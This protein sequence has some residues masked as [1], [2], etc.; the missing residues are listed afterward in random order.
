[1][2]KIKLNMKRYLFSVSVAIVLASMSCLTSCNNSSSTTLPGS[3]D[4]LGDFAGIPRDGAV[5]FIINNNAFVGTGYNYFSNTF[6][7]DFWRYEPNSDSWYPAATFPGI[8]RSGAVAFT[9]NG[10]GYI[11]G[12]Y[13]ILNGSTNP[14]SDF[15]VFDPTAGKI[16]AWSQ[17]ASF[18]FPSLPVDSTVAQRYGCGAFHCY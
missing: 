9:M 15:W 2:H 7:T 18:G 13:N 3:W 11:G 10:K 8:A 4:K 1:M 6:L 14:L 17:I 5:S 12:G 16:G